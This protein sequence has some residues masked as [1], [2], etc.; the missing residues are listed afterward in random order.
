L[1]NYIIRRLLLLI[2]VLVFVA[3]FAFLATNIMPGD[4]VV[5]ILGDFATEEQITLLTQK[6]GL[7]QPLPVRFYRW[8]SNIVRGDFGTSIFLHQ[9]VFNV[10]LQRMEPS[11][12][13]AFLALML[14]IAIGIPMGIIASVNHKTWIDQSVI[15]V[16]LLGISVPSFWIALVGIVVFSVN[17]GWLPAY[18]Y[19]SVF[20][21]G[22]GALRY[23]VIPT[24]II[25]TSVSAILARMTR[26]MMLDVLN[27]DYIRTARAKGLAEKVVIFKHA[28]RN[29]MIPVITL[30]G[31][32]LAA[33]LAGT[34]ISETIFRIP[35]T[36]QLAIQAISRR[37]FPIIQGVMIFTA[38][39]YVFV[40]LIVDI[41]YAVINPRIRYK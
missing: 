6:L 27:Q 20:K 2:P 25:G 33:L 39:I 28:L 29:A 4:P 21:E 22:L 23:L 18:G 11:L 24:I 1:F 40:N 13:Q 26:S 8:I 12:V 7:D 31:F 41:T 9:P 17:L 3:L 34:W 35:G 16:A 19:Q 30:I 32:S 15:F 10:I 38:V 37:D 14:A 5:M 36:G